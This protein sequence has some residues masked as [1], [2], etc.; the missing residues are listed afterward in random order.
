MRMLRG[1]WIA[2]GVAAVLG[3]A[4]LGPGGSVGDAAVDA[5]DEAEIARVAG[6]FTGAEAILNRRLK[7]DPRDARSWRLLGD[8]DVSRGQ[9]FPERWKEN[10]GW[11]IEA[12]ASAVTL[13]PTD[14]RAWGRLAVAVV[15]AAE[16]PATAVPPETV[17]GWPLAAGIDACPGAPALQLALASTVEPAGSE[18]VRAAVGGAPLGSIGWGSWIPDPPASPGAPFVVTAIPTTGGAVDG[19]A[20][21]A[22]TA[23]ERI[24]VTRVEGDGGGA[25][26]VY[27]DRRFAATVP[28]FAVTRAPACP[29]TTW[30][31]V[32]P[33]R[34]PTGECAPGPQDR[35]A[36][37]LYDPAILRPAGA[38]H[39]HE[40]SIRLATLSWDTVADTPVTCVGEPV[41]RQFVDTPS[42]RVRYDRAVPQTRWVP[43][44][45]GRVAASVEHADRI[46]AAA[47]G[48]G[49]ALA[50]VTVVFGLAL[51]GNVD[52]TLADAV[53]TFAGAAAV[54]A[55]WTALYAATENL[56]VSTANHA[57]WNFG[58][59]LSGLSLSGTD[60][61]RAVAPFES[62]YAG[63]AW[64]TGGA[65]GPESSAVVIGWV[66]AWT[67][68]LWWWRG[69]TAPLS[70]RS[71]P[72]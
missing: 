46:L 31:F 3:C 54:G 67:A 30:T 66:V 68:A 22:F 5:G 60:D 56:W 20:P 51:V 6:D 43:R 38:A 57:L 37:E 12:Y 13:A 1:A 19:S 65:F 59:V 28:A 18:V 45:S 34:M 62:A 42:C 52:G 23:P 8:V 33:D 10:L 16:N 24:T 11:A 14:C 63:P 7:A 27:A 50:A 21:R 72:R 15:A 49:A 9:R 32:G 2:A 40:P 4:G 17:A 70:G 71:P 61:W 47:V 44:S 29:G 64:A 26:V 39:F 48:P 69:R 35:Q 58:I 36:S 41:G 55:L 25:R 53:G